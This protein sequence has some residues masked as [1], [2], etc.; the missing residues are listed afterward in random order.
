MRARNAQEARTC[1]RKNWRFPSHQGFGRGSDFIQGTGSGLIL[2]AIIH[3]TGVGSPPETILHSSWLNSR[4]TVGSL[5]S[6]DKAN[7]LPDGR[8]PNMTLCRRLA[9][10]WGRV[11]QAGV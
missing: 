1:A 5:C 3:G 9:V 8:R 4:A 2:T 10:W 7:L 11:R 6:P